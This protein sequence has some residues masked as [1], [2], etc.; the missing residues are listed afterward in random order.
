[1]DKK[2]SKIR[3]LLLVAIVIALVAVAA[4]FILK[5]LEDNSETY[6]DMGWS[7]AFSSDKEYKVTLYTNVNGCNDDDDQSADVTGAEQKEI[8]DTDSEKFID[9]FNNQKLSDHKGSYNYDIV[10]KIGATEIMID[11]EKGEGYC[12]IGYEDKTGWY[13]YLSAKQKDLLSID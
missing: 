4:I 10:V 7:L 6:T 2:N 12:I 3:K 5:Y 13:F 9:A 8:S 1:M 11:S